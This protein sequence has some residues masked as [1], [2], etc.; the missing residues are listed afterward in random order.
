MPAT[1]NPDFWGLAGWFFLFMVAFAYP[2]C[3]PTEEERTDM[4][5][6]F[7]SLKS[8]LPCWSCRSNF[9]KNLKKY[10]LTDNILR[11][12]DSLIQW[13]VDM[14]NE[15]NKE[16]NKPVLSYEDTIKKFTN[17]YE[18][19]GLEPKKSCHW[20]KWTIVTFLLVSIIGYIIYKKRNT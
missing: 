16:I 1:Y 12:R 18:N 3:K 17:I 15:V 7:L 4:K 20:L 5:N 8:I 14:Y 6:F 2:S 13:L 10:P 11:S 19:G 9:Q